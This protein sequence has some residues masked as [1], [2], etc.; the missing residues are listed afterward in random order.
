MRPQEVDAMD[1]EEF[2]RCAATAS[3]LVEI[4]REQINSAVQ[5][6]VG[7]ILF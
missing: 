7:S 2:I 3:L 4:E 5:K 6:N 1:D